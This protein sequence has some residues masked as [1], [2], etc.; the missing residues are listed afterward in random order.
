[1]V[2]QMKKLKKPHQA[3][4]TNTTK[5]ILFEGTSSSP[6]E[7]IQLGRSLGK[8]LPRGAIVC[9]FGDLAT[10][11]TTFIK[12]IAA[13]IGNCHLQDVNSPTFVYLNIYSGG[14]TVYHFDLYR[15]RDSDEFLSMGFD[16][17][18]YSDGICCIEWSERIADILPRNRLYTVTITHCGENKRNLKIEH[19]HE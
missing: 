6:D 12:G 14:K 2:R 5:S 10:G 4:L 11:K 1:M 8:D 7:T 15:L 9:F 3:M 13:T 19:H 17:M 16:E 18:L